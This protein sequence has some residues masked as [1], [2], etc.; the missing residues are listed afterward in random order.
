M[1]LEEIHSFDT[2]TDITAKEKKCIM[3]LMKCPN[4]IVHGLSKEYLTIFPPPPT[5]SNDERVGK[6]SVVVE[7]T[8]KHTS[9]VFLSRNTAGF[10]CHSQ[11]AKWC[12]T[13]LS[14]SFFAQDGRMLGA[15]ILHQ[16]SSETWGYPSGNNPQK[17]SRLSVMM[18]CGS[19][20]LKSVST[21]LK[22]AALQRTLTSV[23][24]DHCTRNIKI[25]IKSCPFASLAT[26]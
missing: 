11:I 5:V 24:G 6:L 20:K 2:A 15:T 3:F 22:M 10:V 18:Q 12:N 9:R 4:F 16:V 25:T 14:H 19:I 1:V 7:G 23:P 26:S 21:A 17:F 13:C 8:F